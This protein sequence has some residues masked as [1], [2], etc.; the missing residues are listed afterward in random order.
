MVTFG[1]PLKHVITVR[2]QILVSRTDDDPPAPCGFKNAF[3][4]TFKTSPCVPAPRAHLLKP[5]F[6]LPEASLSC[7]GS[8]LIIRL[9]RLNHT[10]HQ[11]KW[12]CGFFFLVVSSG[13]VNETRAIPLKDFSLSLSF[14]Y[15]NANRRHASLAGRSAPFCSKSSTHDS[16][17]S[18]GGR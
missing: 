13:S 3:V 11:W 4:C 15:P 1:E 6:H 9:A 12:A 8:A 18:R 5:F 16:G 10:W 14:S 2:G 7:V 17:T